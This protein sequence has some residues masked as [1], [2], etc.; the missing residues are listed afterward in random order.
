MMQ[1]L[2]LISPKM[3]LYASVAA[4]V[5]GYVGWSQFQIKR[6][7]RAA[8]VLQQSLDTAIQATIVQDASIKALL[9]NAEQWQQAQEQ[10]QHD[11]D[12][13]RRSQRAASSRQ[14]EMA[15]I[16]EDYDLER[17]AEDDPKALENGINVVSDD[18][19]GVLNCTTSECD[20]GGSA[21]PGQ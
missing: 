13:M 19:I 8:E 21:D 11:L 20:L 12:E 9:A 6:S 4:I 3:A 15:K 16:L 17:L 18:I 14:R 5:V 10:F 1:F 7:V 2:G